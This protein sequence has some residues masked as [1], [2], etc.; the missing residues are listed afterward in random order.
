MKCEECVTTLK[1][2]DCL[3][4]ELACLETQEY[5]KNVL[6]KGRKDPTEDSE[7]EVK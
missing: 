1:G 5:V 3:E 7:K 4:S 2:Y 6:L